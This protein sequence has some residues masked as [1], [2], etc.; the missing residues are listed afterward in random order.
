MRWRRAAR[1][2]AAG[3]GLVL[4]GC[5]SPPTPPSDT[6]PWRPPESASKPDEVWMGLRA[7]TN[8]LSRPLSLA[9]AADLALQNH[10]AS[11][12]AWRDARAAAAV[13]EQV[14]GYFMPTVSATV[15]VDRQKTVTN[16]NSSV[17]RR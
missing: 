11:R 4:A 3:L 16:T 13:V 15:G 5:V 17:L 2:A 8:D 9:E 6:A 7:Q 12:R 1:Q 10:P 14:Q